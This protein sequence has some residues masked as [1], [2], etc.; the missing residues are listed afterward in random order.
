VNAPTIVSDLR[1]DHVGIACRD[2]DREQAAFETLGYR[3]EGSTFEDPI[4]GIKGRF[5][6]GTD[7]RMELVAPLGEETGVLT[8]VLARGFKMYHTAYTTLDLERS[9]SEVVHA[10]GKVMVAPVSAVAF[11]GRRIAFVYLPNM[12]LVELIER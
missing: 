11:G 1:F 8:N 6:T 4:Q 10:R 2:L 12:L 5:L 3:L 7:P 9:L